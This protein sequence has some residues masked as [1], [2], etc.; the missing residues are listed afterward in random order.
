MI[1]LSVTGNIDYFAPFLLYSIH[2]DNLSGCGERKVVEGSKGR[3]RNY[4]EIEDSLQD[5]KREVREGI[6]VPPPS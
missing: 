6:T 5:G 3:V 1:F 2:K 4:S